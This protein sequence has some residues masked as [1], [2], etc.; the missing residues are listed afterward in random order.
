MKIN[1]PVTGVEKTYSEDTLIISTTNPKGILTHANKDFVDIC[2]FSLDELIK[3]NHNVV[4]HPDMPPAAFAN[5]W[6]TLKQRKPWM[7]IVKN[8]CK[9]G[10][11]YWVD[12]YVTPMIEGDEVIGYESVRA[13]P[14][15]E[16][17]TQ[18]EKIYK[19]I[20]DGKKPRARLIDISMTTRI[21][22]GFVAILVP[23]F[24][25]MALFA[26]LSGAALVGGLA[27]AGGAAY[28]VAHLVARPLISAARATK[29][30]VD[31]EIMQLVYFGG[32]DE[33]TQLRLS[34][35]M[36]QGLLKTVLGRFAESATTITAFAE[37]TAATVEQ[38]S[39]G[40]RQ[41]HSATD[42]VATAMNEMSATVR[43]VAK[44]AAN[45]AEAARQA[46][47]EANQGKVVI[48]EAMGAMDCLA[49][50]V[51]RASEAIRKLEADS[52]SIGAVLD[53]IRGIAEQTNL[54]ALNAAIEAARAGDQGRG[55]AVVADEVRTLA[56]R[57]QQSTQEIHAMIERL[58]AGARDA[59]HL[60]GQG[61]SQTQ[62]S[63]DLVEKAVEFL[64]GI[65]G[66]VATINDMNTQI[67]S[68]AEEQGA[69]AEDINRNIVEIAQIAD[70]TAQ[71]AQQTAG[72]SEEL[73]GLAA[74]LQSRIRQLKL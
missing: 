34:I 3:K 42:Q 25:F 56:S 52:E 72:T 28:G 31:N 65:A 8:R 44:N 18:A 73:A 46:D 36:L 66:S 30:I 41:Q 27:L 23:T 14:A 47:D 50:E 62:V 53:V 74:Q 35:K 39:Q 61:S 70:Q 13:K 58:Q 40:I 17:V 37:Q 60:M 22:L 15:A 57:T 33:V 29:G 5:L 26:N 11:H 7:G 43:E 32:R 1:L 9:N 12:A 64:A 55:F 71:G 16:H 54:L 48:T 67:A 45:A 59:V 69:V 49:G 10:D 63:V 51:E 38:T 24:V 20:S 6:D 4:R 21:F 19:Q 68:A 2:G